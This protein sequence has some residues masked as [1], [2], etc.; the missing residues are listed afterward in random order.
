[1]KTRTYLFSKPSIP[2]ARTR[3]KQ[4]ISGI[5]SALSL[6]SPTLIECEFPPLAELNKLG[7][8]SLRSSLQAEDANIAFVTK[9]VKDIGIPLFGPKVS[10][11]Y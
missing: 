10:L 6:P 7:D 2:T 11:V 3:D 1:M 4:A 5:K 8:G 9:I